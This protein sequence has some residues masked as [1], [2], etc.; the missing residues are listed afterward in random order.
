MSRLSIAAGAVALLAVL[1]YANAVQNGFALDDE[2]IILR[3]DAVHGLD[4]VDEALSSPYWPGAPGRIAMYR[5]VTSASFALEWDL[6]GAERPGGYHAT[7]VLLHAVVSVLV[8]LVLNVLAGSG[9][10][11]A[12]AALFAVHPVHVE[13]V[14][15]LVGR[16]ELL[17][18]LFFLAA[19]R[20]YLG[21]R[22]GRTTAAGIGVLYLLAVA[23]KEIGVTLPAVLLIVETVRPG[24]KGGWRGWAS[25]S[26]ERWPVYAA[27]VAGLAVYMTARMVVLDTA[28]GNDPA[29]FL[30]GEGTAARIWTAMAVWP[31]YARLLLYPRDLVADYSP[32][33]LSAHT[34]FDAVVAAGL[35]VGLTSV[36]LVALSWRRAPLVAAG[37]AWFAV[38]VL[39]V[40]N[41]FFSIG[42]VLAERTLYLP[43]VG[44]S[45]A[46]AGIVALLLERRA[47]AARG[48]ALA[49]AAILL[50]LAGRTW[51]RT[52]TWESSATV[53]AALAAKHPESFRV[54][55]VMGDQLLRAGR[56]EEGLERFRVALGMM[57]A[58]YQLRFQ[59]ARALLAA[60]R[61]T[62]AA[63]QLDV[64]SRLIPEHPEAP[65]LLAATLVRL[66]RWPE[67]REVAEAA[68]A[69]F[70]GHRGAWH[71]L[72]LARAGAG[73]PAG[74]LAARRQSLDL[75][76]PSAHWLQWV[77]LAEL[78]LR[79]GARAEAH[80]AL[81]RARELA[82]E[83]AAPPSLRE[84]EGAI[85]TGTGAA[86][87]Y[88]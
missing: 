63:E 56:R 8:L 36:A 23:S 4:R 82:P 21:G 55:W 50:L 46:V 7:N 3:N 48:A 43:S 85:A 68:A 52:P 11:I 41:L 37:I 70:P 19:V 45:L 61:L 34:T 87:P 64:A 81:T 9:P 25:R 26:L 76:G 58:H 73:D 84:L 62:E 80:A 77:H 74:A 20:L 5:P 40:S 12:G 69:R 53:L 28:L 14:A 57:P 71:Q 66:A 32:A 78:H 60:G 72:A 49:G 15:N 75:A 67:A 54:Q 86:L 88:R 39:P 17:A 47:A 24:A 31:E 33:V 30:R 10:A 27:T 2:F 16:G 79:V 35:V 6:W 13:A 59:Y 51:T 18:A 1:V 83:D 29:P 65:I 38:V 44:L 22:T 42:I